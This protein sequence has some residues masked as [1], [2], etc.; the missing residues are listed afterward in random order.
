MVHRQSAQRSPARNPETPNHE[1]DRA[2]ARQHAQLEEEPTPGRESTTRAGR[3][4]LPPPR[5]D[6]TSPSLSLEPRRPESALPPPPLRLAR[7]PAPPTA[8][9][10]PAPARLRA[11]DGRAPAP[12]SVRVACRRG[13]RWDAPSSLLE[14]VVAQD[15]PGPSVPRSQA[16]R[17]LR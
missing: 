11:A 2:S 4:R 3:G 7:L 5:V 9:P 6:R 1:N 16:A 17:A 15:L 8:P 10:R 12:A 13:R 14:R